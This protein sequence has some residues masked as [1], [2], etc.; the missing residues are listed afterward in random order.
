MGRVDCLPLL[1]RVAEVPPHG[2]PTYASGLL[3]SD[4]WVDRCRVPG[5]SVEARFNH[6][7]GKRRVFVAAGSFGAL[8]ALV[9]SIVVVVVFEAKSR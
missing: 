1:V 4:A 6:E 9:G 7:V 2:C 5:G 8:V 3:A